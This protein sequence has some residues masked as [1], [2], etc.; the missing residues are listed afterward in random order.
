MNKVTVPAV[1][2]A[3]H[4]DPGGVHQRM[5][6]E[7]VQGAAEVPDVLRQRVPS[8]HDG[9]DQVGVAR[10]VVL[11]IPVEPFAEATQVGREHHIALPYQLQGVVAVGRIGVLQS[12]RLGLA[13]P[14][15]V[16]GQ[17]RCAGGDPPVGHQQVR[18]HRHGVLGVED[19]QVPAVAVALHRFE[20]LGV[21]G[22]RQR[23]WGPEARSGGRAGA[24]AMPRWSRGRLRGRGSSCG[25]A[26]NRVIHWYHDE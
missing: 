7:D 11:G 13:R 18:R 16:A 2:E 3:D 19:D 15:P 22:H 25:V 17:H 6:A 1:R 9:M 8:G 12:D 26:A 20:R 4:A 23:A 14:V 5:L 24:R 10:V 21:E